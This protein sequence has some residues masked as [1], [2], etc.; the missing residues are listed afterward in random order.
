M[1]VRLHVFGPF[2]ACEAATLASADFCLSVARL[3]TSLAHNPA[4]SW[5]DR[6]LSRGKTR[7]LRPIYPSHLRPPVR[8]T[9]GFLLPSA[10]AHRTAAFLHFV[11]LGPGLC[12][13]L[14][15]HAPSRRRNRTNMRA[16]RRKDG[17]NPALQTQLLFG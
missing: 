15:L 4:G 6:Q 7:D 1:P 5:A 9:L 13:Q 11:F 17:C 8:M 12:L 10:F 2:A 3:T 14:P 16:A